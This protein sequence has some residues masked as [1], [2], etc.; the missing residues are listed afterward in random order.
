MVLNERQKRGYEALERNEVITIVGFKSYIIR[1]F[2]FF[3]KYKALT[4]VG[5][6]WLGLRDTL[7]NSKNKVL[8][9]FV[10]KYNFFNTH[11]YM[12]K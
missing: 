11:N 1:M 3:S 6:K 2:H 4:I 5:F 9:V 12:K 10:F 7:N 8:T